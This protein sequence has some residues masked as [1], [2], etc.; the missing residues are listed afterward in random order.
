MSLDYKKRNMSKRKRA[1]EEDY[2]AYATLM[3]ENKHPSFFMQPLCTLQEVMDHAWKTS[4]VHYK[5][6][7]RFM[8]H[9]DG[10][11]ALVHACLNATFLPYREGKLHSSGVSQVD[12]VVMFRRELAMA[13]G[14]G[15]DKGNPNSQYI[16][17][18]SDGAWITSPAADVDDLYHRLTD[19]RQPLDDIMIEH[20]CNVLNIDLYIVDANSMALL[21]DVP[22]IRYQGRKAVVVLHLKRHYELLGITLSDGECLTVFLPT[23]PWIQKLHSQLEAA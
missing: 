8:T 16:H 19:P 2:D 3:P 9:Q 5:G 13:L 7:T 18:L 6:M 14:M 22:A 15:W 11:S 1:P 12:L 17:R 4:A 10:E 20:M 23:H 21:R